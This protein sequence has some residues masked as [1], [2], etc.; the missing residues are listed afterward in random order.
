MTSST[1]IVKIGLC[2]Q[3]MNMYIH[4]VQQCI[5][6]HVELLAAYLA[7]LYDLMCQLKETGHREGKRSD[8]CMEAQC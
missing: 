6:P 1:R 8:V 4:N 2:I 7:I 3:F 5:S